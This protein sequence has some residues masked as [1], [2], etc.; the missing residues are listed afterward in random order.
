MKDLSNQ[1]KNN[2]PPNNTLL[3][4][5]TFYFWALPHLSKFSRW[6]QNHPKTTRIIITVF[7]V[8]AIANA[9]FLGTLLYLMNWGESKLLLPTAGFLLCICFLVYPKKNQLRFA[10]VKQK[11]LDFSF[12][13]LYTACLSLS[14]NNH[15]QEGDLS[16]YSSV[17]SAPNAVFVVNKPRMENQSPRKKSFRKKIKAKIQEFRS[18]LRNI[19]KQDKDDTK[20][21]ILLI[22]S[23]I[24]VTA[25]GIG[26]A[27]GTCAL[28]CAG[29][30]GGA[31]FLFVFGGI[32][33]ALISVFGIAK[34]A[35][36]LPNKH[37]HDGKKRHHHRRKFNVDGY[38]YDG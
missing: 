7:H 17:I 21:R 38:R 23:M 19:K 8:L 14:V 10:Y 15:L 11:L 3:Q 9:L 12:V 16:P 25:L 29:S 2:T 22:L 31:V 27:V 20:K 26:V 35:K 33:I 18:E 4:L 36:E 24:S 34:L 37:G 32:A 13:I 5:N 1:E 30:V 28:L 6:A